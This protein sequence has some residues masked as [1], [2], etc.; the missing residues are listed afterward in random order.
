MIWR[1]SL[2]LACAG[3]AGAQVQSVEFPWNAYP[4]QLWERELAW[5]KNIGAGHV[6]L[7]PGGNSSDLSEVISIIRRLQMEADLEGPVPDALQ[8]L[9]KAHGGPLTDA[10]AAPLRVSALAA[11]ALIES[12]ETLAAGSRS[13]LWTDVEDTLREGIYKAGAVNFA[14]AESPATLALRREVQFRLYW[15]SSLSLL[16]ETPGAGARLP[17]LPA[18]VT[19]KQFAADS[20][21][22][23]V[24]VINRSGA[25]FQGDLKVLYPA[26]KRGMV[27]PD[28]GVPAHGVVAIPVNIPLTA[29]PLCRACTAFATSDHLVYATAE[30]TSMEYENGILAME[31]SAP[32]GGEVVLQLSREPS[33]PLLAGGKPMPFDWDD[34]EHRVR[35]KIPVGRGAGANVRVGLAID[36]PDATAFFDTARVLIIGE[37]N[38]LSAE[39]SSEAIQQRSR[40]R[41]PAGFTV[42]QHA[43][44]D[45]PLKL[46]YDIQVPESAVHG[47][48]A[49]LA[50]EVDG[51]QMSHARPQLLRPVSLRFAGQIEVRMS[52]KSALPLMPPTVPVN[53]RPG[54]DITIS[55]RNNATEI[56][57]FHLEL[58]VDGLEFL[59]AKLDVSVGASTARE[60]SFR[61]F[62]RDAAP[63][64][65]AGMARLS[66]A[67]SVNTAVQFVVIPPNGTAAYSAGGFSALES[68]RQRAVFMPGRWL[69]FIDKENGQNLLPSGWVAMPAGPEKTLEELKLMV[70]KVPR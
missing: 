44:K 61:V 48:H 20:G 37:T 9:T 70:P 34:H 1:V 12:R 11:W 55:I 65:H 4:K 17:P 19:V 33:G 36:A 5:L 67:A 8:A 18:G 28:V 38:H 31:F 22:S 16:K 3:L 32:S 27:L 26:A 63:G 10:P 6:S 53:Q 50:L 46:V 62:A 21:V 45:S 25:A 39:F 14:G 60:L 15:G 58:T 64:L 59:P 49:D 47:D 57:N 40:L 7:A 35:L 56:R 23:L 66:G 30:M 43:G 69:E 13:V 52:A 42:E 68:S 24:S 41:L 29:G 2:F 51:M 54:R